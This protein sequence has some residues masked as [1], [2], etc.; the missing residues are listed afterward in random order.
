MNL[1]QVTDGSFYG[2]NGAYGTYNGSIYK[3]TS[4]NVFSAFMFPSTD[5]DGNSP[6]STL[7]QNTNGLVYGTTSAGGPSTCSPPCQGA[8]FSVSTGDAPFVNLEPTQ[9]AE[10]RGR[11][12]GH[13]WAGLHERLGGE[14]RRRDGYYEDA[15]RLHVSDGYG[16]RGGSYRTRYGDHGK[17]YSNQPA[18]VQS[19]ADVGELHSAQWPGGDFRHHHW[20]GADPSYEGDFQRDV[21]DVRGELRQTDHGYRAHRRDHRQDRSHHQGRFGVEHDELHRQLRWF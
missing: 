9:L 8:F 10:Q 2:V 20:H 17:D 15:L 18:N 11:E 1:L 19:K 4:A 7:I 12:G 21:G 13:V 6:I 14:V 16:T 5:A 3:L